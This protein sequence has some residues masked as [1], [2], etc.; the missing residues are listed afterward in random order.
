MHRPSTPTISPC[1]PP[2]DNADGVMA[3]AP[4]AGCGGGSFIPA[5]SFGLFADPGGDFRRIC[6]VL[7]PVL[8]CNHD[9]FE[10]SFQQGYR[11]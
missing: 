4:S 5:P 10:A 11:S 6:P 9:L 8:C 7:A 3:V 1:L 2:A